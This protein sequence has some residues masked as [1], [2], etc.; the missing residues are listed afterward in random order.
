ME[1]NDRLRV[2]LEGHLNWG[3]CRLDGVIGMLLALAG[4]TPVHPLP[5]DQEN[6]ALLT[7]V[8]WWA[9]KTGEW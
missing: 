1:L 8:F 7:I 2:I 9:H 4:I 3:K 5:S 6:L